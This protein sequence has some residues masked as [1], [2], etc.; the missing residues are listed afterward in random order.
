VSRW[1]DTFGPVQ[2][3]DEGER[4]VGGVE[5]VGLVA[6][7][8]FQGEPDPGGGGVVGEPL[9]GMDGVGAAACGGRPGMAA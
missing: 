7:D 5:Q 1:A 3:G 2:V 6:V 4:G 8:D 9:D